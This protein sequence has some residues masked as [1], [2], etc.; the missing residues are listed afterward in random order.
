[1]RTDRSA[2][3]PPESEAL[4][5]LKRVHKWID[6]MQLAGVE[7]HVAIAAIML[8]VSERLLLRHGVEEAAKALV[9]QAAT[10]SEHGAAV[11]AALRCQQLNNRPG[12]TC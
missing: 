10:V 11:L 8:G 2:A 9:R 5:I 1:M 7:E 3:Q 6:E 12:G 4:K